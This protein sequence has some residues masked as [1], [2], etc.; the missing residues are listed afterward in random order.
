MI[1][2]STQSWRCIELSLF[3]LTTKLSQYAGD[4]FLSEFTD[5][6]VNDVANSKS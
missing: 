4:S 5:E 6:I 3:G 1:L 2:D